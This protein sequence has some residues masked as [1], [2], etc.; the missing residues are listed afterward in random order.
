M[1]S[2]LLWMLPWLA[3]AQRGPNP[4]AAA[5]WTADLA[6]AAGER[7]TLRMEG[8]VFLPD[9]RTP[10]AGIV[11]YV[12]QTGRDG[13]YGSDGRGGP[14]LRA[15]LRTDSMGRYRYD[16]IVP[17]P[18]PDGSTPAHIHVQLWGGKAARQYFDVYFE[19][20]SL[21]GEPLRA[22]ARREGRFASVV[23]LSPGGPG[24]TGKQD[25]RLKARADR[26]EASIQH[27][28]DAC[29]QISER[30]PT[31]GPRMEFRTR[32]RLDAEY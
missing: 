4:C 27:G 24:M 17:A 28:L 9:G 22:A 18:Y 12:Y 3:M 16:T 7:A 32:A 10:A 20:D 21:I 19:H 23:R 25:F 6:R 13:E 5:A 31:P 30:L 15:W 11:M 29:R 1:K 8:R 14:R 26:F 2:A